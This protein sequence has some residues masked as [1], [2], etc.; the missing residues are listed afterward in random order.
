[1]TSYEQLLSLSKK[2]KDIIR[3]DYAD[4]EDW[5]RVFHPYYGWERPHS[6]K[7]YDYLN[8]TEME[9]DSDFFIIRPVGED[10]RDCFGVNHD[11]VHGDI[12]C[13]SSS[14]YDASL[15]NKIFELK[16]WTSNRQLTL[17]D[18]IPQTQIFTKNAC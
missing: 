5:Q 16:S 4:V 18:I 7:M 12:F 17:Y 10:N 1:M 13:A 8:K 2:W 3:I 15:L 9:I 11:Y 6:R 14:S